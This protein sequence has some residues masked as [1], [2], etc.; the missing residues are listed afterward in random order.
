M[1]EAAKKILIKRA[2]ILASAKNKIPE[3]RRIILERG[4]DK[5]HNLLVYCG[6]STV[7]EAVVNGTTIYDEKQIL[8]V[9]RLLGQ[10][11]NMDVKKFTSEESGEERQEIKNG[12]VNKDYQAIVAIRCLDE[13][14]NIPSIKTAYILASTTNPKQYIQRR[15]RV[16]R[17][18]EG[19]EFSI[20][21]DFIVLP[22]EIEYLYNYSKEEFDIESGLI[23]R[24][25]ARLKEFA[26]AAENS[27]S[28]YN[29]F[30]DPLS[31]LFTISNNYE[32][33]ECMQQI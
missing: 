21:H 7:K 13:G 22:C 31:D 33:F 25:L 29:E 18:A 14:V 15:G 28:L 16:L 4:D 11:L 5:E 17:K 26:D 2:R 6:D 3:L 9:A 12:F 8:V 24:E 23:K 10:E 1:C 27:S 20:I 30:I 32:D 19:K